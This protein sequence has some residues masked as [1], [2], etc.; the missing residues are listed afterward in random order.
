ML[1]ERL[2]TFRGDQQTKGMEEL[3]W[4]MLGNML[5]VLLIVTLWSLAAVGEHLFGLKSLDVGGHGANVLW[6]LCHA[7][8]SLL[9]QSLWLLDRQAL[10]WSHLPGLVRT[11][12]QFW[13]QVL[14]VDRAG[15]TLC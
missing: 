6:V 10:L 12:R 14:G 7:K 2:R 1:Y 4:P 13:S 9:R 15:G 8:S 11:V 3:R 5:A